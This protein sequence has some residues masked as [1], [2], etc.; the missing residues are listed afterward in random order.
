MTVPE[1]M[2]AADCLAI[3]RHMMMAQMALISD[4]DRDR[5]ARELQSAL[6]ILD[7]ARAREKQRK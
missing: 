1:S 3:V 5:C 4:L 2:T 7:A 6:D